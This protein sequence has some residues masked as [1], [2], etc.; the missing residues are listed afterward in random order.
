MKPKTLVTILKILST[1]GFY[2]M[3]LFTLVF[4]VMAVLNITTK[5]EAKNESPGKGLVF[6][7]AELGSS[8]N[9][10]TRYYSVDS[11]FQ[12]QPVQNEYVLQIS[13]NT[14]FGYYAIF[15][16]TIHMLLG[17]VVL[18]CFMKIFKLVQL[19]QPFTFRIIKLLKI[20]AGAF[21]I[22]DIIKMIDYPIFNQLVHQSLSLPRLA[23]LTDIGNGLLTGVIIWI[24]A[25][26]YQR[27]VALQTE[28]DLT[29]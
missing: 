26:I 4:I 13:P 8:K 11:V 19:E 15:R 12:Y 7:A 6:K 27:G 23:L 5:N 1:I 17:V 24:I 14:S 20:L 16:N 21:I 10:G 9:E 28:N 18:W 29:V 25:I 22:S 2:L 3:S